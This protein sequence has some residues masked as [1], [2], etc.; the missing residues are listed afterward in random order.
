MS[1]ETVHALNTI[2]E[3]FYRTRAAAFSATRERGWP[4]F[5]E[6]ADRVATAP[7]TVLDAGCGNGRF[8]S[9]VARHWPHAGYT[10]L[11]CSEVLLRLAEERSD[12]PQRARFERADFIADPARLPA[13][14]FDLVVLLAVLHHVPSEARRAALLAALASRV[15][16]G[17]ALALSIW[18]FGRFDR[19]AKLEVP[20]ARSGVDPAER[21]PGD[22]LLS[23]GGD[24]DVPRY[25]HDIGPAE[26]KRLLAPLPLKHDE[27]FL[28]DGRE[29]ALN[30][31]VVLRANA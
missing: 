8:G 18:R 9:V 11:D 30:A 29:G 16:P 14:A 17:G 24:A 3:R 26:L 28:A 12:R 1:P 27:T 6:L 7:E 22:H 13:G 25:C 31:Y 19:F 15:A 20:W 23:F 5:T 21:E 2:N 10:G 4:G